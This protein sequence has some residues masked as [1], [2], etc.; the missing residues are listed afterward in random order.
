MLNRTAFILLLGLLFLSSC[1]HAPVKTSVEASK[2]E[3]QITSYE[4]LKS[5][6]FSGQTVRIRNFY[7]RCKEMNQ[8]TGEAHPGADAVGGMELDTFEYFGD[9]VFKNKPPYLATSKSQLILV[10]GKFYQDYVKLRFYPDETVEIIAKFYDI[11]NHEIIDLHDISCRL[12]KGGDD[13]GGVCLY[14][15]S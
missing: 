14:Y 8:E 6:L 10:N 2:T 7:Y 1:I 9:S 3:T 13:D 4:E 11:E 5:V 15:G 12:N